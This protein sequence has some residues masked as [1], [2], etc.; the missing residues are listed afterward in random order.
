MK[1]DHG[2]RTT[3]RESS[4][5]LAPEAE[6]REAGLAERVAESASGGSASGE[7]R[8]RVRALWRTLQGEGFWAGRPA[9]FVRLVACNMWTG[10]DADRARDAERNGAACPLW[11]DTEFTQEGSV[12]L[13]AGDLADA[14]VE[15]GAGVRFCVLTGGEPLLQADAALIRALHARGLSVAVET[16]GTVPLAQAFGDEAD[17]PDWIVCSPKLPV[18][19]LKI[20]AC[21]E[22]KLV[23]PDYRPEAYAPLAAR[24]RERSLAGPLLWLQPEDGPRFA[25]AARLA[26]ALALEDPRWRVSVQGHKA[27]G[28]D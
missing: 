5:P 10:Y 21:D 6:E 28:V 27:L 3:D 25:E 16:N 26:V 17:W 11:C 4:V 20:E 15:T 18:D 1:E 9:V 24:V 13:S 12:R 19:R 23:V 2:P 8:Y 22:L 14:V 7:K